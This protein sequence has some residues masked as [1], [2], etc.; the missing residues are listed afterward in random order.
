[1]AS[2]IVSKTNSKKNT[3]KEKTNQE[4][5][6]NR[7]ARETEEGTDKYDREVLEQIWIKDDTDWE[8]KEVL[9]EHRK[10]VMKF[11]ETYK[12]R[13]LKLLGHV[14]RCGEEDPMR[15]VTFQKIT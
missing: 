15:Q 3:R 8:T 6:E 2:R 10:K 14:I 11:S 12:L 1:M 9:G 5:Q 13:K 4:K 7:K